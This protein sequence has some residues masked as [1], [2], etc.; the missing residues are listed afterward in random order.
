MSKIKS[1]SKLD[2]DSEMNEIFTRIDHEVNTDNV[3]MYIQ[4]GLQ[5]FNSSLSKEQLRKGMGSSFRKLKYIVEKYGVNDA[6]MNVLMDLVFSNK[7]APTHAQKVV[8]IC[9]PRG[10][11]R[12]KDVIRIFRYLNLRDKD[13][14]TTTT[15][16]T[17][18]KK[19][20]LADQELPHQLVIYLLKWITAL[21]DFID[22]PQDITRLYGV[23]FLYIDIKKLR[24]YL[25]HLLYYM[26]N[27][28]HV[29]TFRA[30]QLLDLYEKVGPEPELISLL[31]VYKTYR[32]DIV[33]P[34]TPPV[35][36]KKTVFM[37]PM[38]ELKVK[39]INIRNLWENK[40]HLSSMDMTISSDYKPPIPLMSKRRKI[41]GSQ[42]IEIP[43]IDTTTLEQYSST[44]GDIRDV[45]Q[46]AQKLDKLALPDQMASVLDNRLLQHMIACDPRESAVIRLSHWLSHSLNNLLKERNQS[47]SYKNS[48]KELLQKCITMARLTKAHVPTIETFLENYISKWNGWEFEDEIFELLTFIRPRSFEEINQIYLKPLYRLYYLSNIQWKS[49]LILCYTEWLKNWALLDWKRH[50][51]R[52]QKGSDTEMDELIWL[53]QG[54]DFNTDY[55]QTIQ[56]F[57]YHVDRL[58]VIG[59]IM[60]DDHPLLQHASLSFFE[61]VSSISIHHDIP[62]IIIPA[63]PLIYRSFF[64]ISGMAVS[65]LCGIIYQYKRAFEENDRKIDDWVTRHST[66]YLN[67]FNTHVMDVCSALWRNSAFTRSNEEELPF[68]LS[69]HITQVYNNLCESRG[70]SANLVLSLTHSASLTGFS[71]RFL[72]EKENEA[73][74][75]IRHEGPVTAQ[76]LKQLSDDGGISISFMDYRVGLLDDLK[77]KGFHGVYNLLYDCMSSLIERKKEHSNDDNDMEI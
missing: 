26:T 71:E 52:R 63:A 58:S 70:E 67:N 8:D 55:F 57:I 21:Y 30:N 77:K 3:D 4:E 41:T 24:P 75:K 73:N 49:K 29:K 31:R 43:P 37:N 1:Q 32:Q 10:S 22:Y 18:R 14:S 46:L 51:E 13:I 64:S 66:D 7:L 65:R 48:L 15:T 16:T 76:S 74:V 33:L 62:E 9:L 59:L 6:Q 72:Q 36:T 56:H 25:C 61:F 12:S 47:I 20:A 40:N 23:L 5:L 34:I 38:P 28:P 45:N 2:S 35:K 17:K 54:L 27:R 69:P 19:K 11:L 50:S 68:S 53:F 60:E 39:L 42:H 44:I